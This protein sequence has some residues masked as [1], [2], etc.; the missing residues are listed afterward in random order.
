M[1]RGILI[2]VMSKEVREVEFDSLKDM[3]RLIDCE[4]VECVAWGCDLD[5]WVDEEG[6]LKNDNK[7][8]FSVPTYPEPFKGNGLLTGGCDEDG[9]TKSCT[10]PLEDARK[11]VKF[12][13]AVD[14]I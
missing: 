10:M 4:L 13:C 11:M 1:K 2:D 5:I 3:Y 7:G 6:L 12:W 14:V 9:R 8:F